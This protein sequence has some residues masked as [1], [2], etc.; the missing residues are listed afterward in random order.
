MKSSQSMDAICYAAKSTE[1]KRGSIPDQ[2]ADA[3]A[4]C[5]HEGYEPIGAY[6]DEAK[7]AYKGSRGDGLAKAMEH[8]ERIAPC[9]LVVQHSDRLARGDAVKGAHLVEYALWAIKTGV[10]IKSVQDPRACETI[11]DAALMGMRNNEDSERKSK[12]TKDG[13]RRVAE[14]GT[15]RGGIVPGGYEPRY[16]HD[17][18]GKVTKR[19]LVKHAEDREAY[20]L[21]WKLAAE[22]RSVQTISLEMNKRGYKTRPP[23]SHIGPKDFD[24]S[25]VIQALSCPAYAGL[26]VWQGETYAAEWEPYVDV[27]TFWRLKAERKDRCHHEKRRRGRPPVGYLL[28]ELAVCG[29]CGEPMHAETDRRRRD[30]SIARHYT[31]RAHREHHREDPAWCPCP[32]F[33]AE[34]VD[35]DVIDGIERLLGDATALL[36]QLESG[37]RAER[38]KLERVAAEA[39]KA[40]QVAEAAAERATAEF[41][42]ATDPEDRSL[43]KDAAK[44]KRA[45]AKRERSRADA[46][47]DALAD[48]RTPDPTA[49]ANALRER[50]AGK[51]ASASGDVKVLNA[52]LREHFEAFALTRNE[53]GSYRIVP[54]LFDES[55]EWLLLEPTADGVVLGR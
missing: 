34:A 41:A 17:A 35:R 16:E 30:G 20:E 12:A 36:R 26:I 27:E 33:D 1:D 25:R 48:E 37:Q 11:L 46:A 51:I 13:L 42:S 53:D 55:M 29:I 3:R 19:S 18:Q 52:A 10:T 14:R 23:H 54:A 38:D 21:L 39:S 22:G 24:T 32:R 5:E 49:S 40:A 7:S 15:W 31:C 9:V 50:L 2:L 4:L 6:Q 47:L 44:V 43:L 8:A 45:E 28:A